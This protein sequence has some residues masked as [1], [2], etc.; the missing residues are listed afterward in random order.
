[1]VPILENEKKK[2]ENAKKKEGICQS[3]VMMMKA[4]LKNKKKSKGGLQ[5]NK[6]E[7]REGRRI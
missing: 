5:K 2:E 7:G 4:T 6:I 3:R 1:M